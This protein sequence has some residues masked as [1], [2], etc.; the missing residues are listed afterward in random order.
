VDLI[1]EDVKDVS[2][3]LSSVSV[4]VGVEPQPD[5][6][7]VEQVDNTTIEQMNP[8]PTQTL[9]AN[10]IQQIGLNNQTTTPTDDISQ[11][12]LLPT[13]TLDPNTIQHIQ[14]TTPTD[15]ISQLTPVPT[16]TLDSNTIQHIQTRKKKI[17]LSFV[18]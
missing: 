3:N 15:D 13:Q 18:Y 11:L 12:T 6:V 7:L 17:N 16:Q 8:E 4:V 9:D 10:T 14:T 2:Q 1:H 5:V